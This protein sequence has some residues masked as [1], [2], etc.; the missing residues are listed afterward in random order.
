[1]PAIK[2][3]HERFDGTGYPDGLRREEIPLGARIIH[4]ADALDAMLTSHVY[5]GAR[6]AEEALGEL[7][8]GAGTQFCPRCVD[9]L[10]R[11]L[12]V[13]TLL[14]GDESLLATA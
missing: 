12:A 2:H 7:R 10:H 8:R 13:D 14:A 3:H 4:V 5:R 6:P 11:A 9:A 1:V